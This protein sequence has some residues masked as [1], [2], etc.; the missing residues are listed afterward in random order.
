MRKLIGGSLALVM[1]FGC[2]SQEFKDN[3]ALNNAV[4]QSITDK[5]VIKPHSKVGFITKPPLV[6]TP[7]VEHANTEWLKKPSSINVV[8]LPLS[9]VLERVMSDVNVPIYFSKDVQPNTPVTLNYSSS[10]Q[11]V[12]NSLSKSSGYGIEFANNRLEISKYI[13][14]V[15]TL[16]IPSG[17]MSG[18]L[19]SQG[20][21]NEDDSARIEGQYL[22]IE[23]DKVGFVE[24]ISDS[25]E[26]ALGGGELAKQS[27]AI[28]PALSSVTVRATVD[29]MQDI[30]SIINHYQKELTKQVTLD[31]QMIEFRSN[32]GT[33]RGIDWNIVRDTGNGLLQFF[34]PGTS[35]ISEGAGYGLAFTGTGKWTGTESFI[36]VLEKQGSV[37]T[38]TP[39]T[40]M[41]LNNQP[42]KITQQN[43]IPYIYE[44][45]SESSEGVIS[46]SVTRRTEVEGVDMMVNS[47][48]Q[49][50][51]VSL[52]ISGQL[53]K[54][55]GR[56]TE[57][58]GDINLG[59][60]STQKS[61]IT[62][63]NK[64]RY[65][66]TYVI[67]SVKQNSSTVEQTKSFWSSFLGGTG[68]NKEAIETLV[69]LTPRKVE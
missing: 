20:V 23:Y 52:R 32:L 64:L 56:D 16:H 36:K 5:T 6:L 58:V 61:E 1:L 46:A 44:A 42:A 18:Q 4:H 54:I 63:A 22:N 29:Q 65:G 66:Q 26:K 35:T 49:D 19:G 34:V 31:I 11:S 30:E 7:I 8:D 62:F 59:M 67:A 43:V 24:E 13:T 69:L 10:R 51:F 12:L 28:S 57:T 17:E 60:L 40:A 14:R 45:S 39:I 25:L 55:V 50:E 53:Q 37:S 68:S 2:A 27:I 21:T 9:L 48:V 3:L 47:S 15:F 33:E 38:Q 41:V